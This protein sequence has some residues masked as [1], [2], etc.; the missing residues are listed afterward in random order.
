[1]ARP[2]TIF[3]GQFADLPFEEVCKM[4]SGYGYEGL[5]IAC[6][7]DHMDVRKAA[8]DPAYVAEKKAILKKYNLGCWALGAHLAGQL[9]G[10]NWDP[11]TD[12]FAP[13]DLAG[14]PEE[15]R[16][17]AVEEMK[18]SARA[19]AAMGCKVVTGFTGSP[20]WAYWYSFPPTTQE[21]VDAGYQRIKDLW[22]PIW[23]VFDEVGVKFALEVHP[24]EIAYDYWSTKKLFETVKRDTLGINFD[25]SHLVWQNMEPSIL[26]RDFPDRIY[27]VHIKDA[28]VD[29]DPRSG[30]LGSHVE[31]GDLRRGWNFRSPGHGDVDFELIIR[32]LNEIAYTGPLSV[33]WE[34]NAMDRTFGAPDACDFVKSLNFAP[35]TI[36]F[37]GAMEN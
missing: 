19:A 17:W 30:I 36:D 27:H 4:M 25:P 35:S 16:A 22:D 12:T 34:D 18:L 3:T 10:D 6:W 2:V 31:F 24:S 23:D 7:G 14:K 5:E 9:V 20:I 21:M 1:M 13:S 15:I 32:A 29:D 28:A 26:I 11:R 37:D 8:T 33:E